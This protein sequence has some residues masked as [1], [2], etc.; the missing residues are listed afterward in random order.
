MSAVKPMVGKT[1]SRLTVVA[2]T[3][4]STDGKAFWLCR[5]V[6]G[7]ETCVE[8]KKLRAGHTRSCGCFAR[9]EQ[10]RRGRE[11]IRHGHARTHSAKPTPEYKTWSS[12]IGRCTNPIDANYAR[13]G[14]RGI[15]VCRRW[16]RF[17]NFLA[18]MGM[19]PH[20][21]LSIDRR[22]NNKGYWKSN[23]RWAT[24]KEQQRNK[25]SNH[26]LTVDGE[27]APLVVW[28]DRYGLKKQTLRMRLTK[29]WSADRAVKEPLHT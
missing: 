18:D 20:A 12:I 15:T 14:G 5:C 3:T 4:T 6:C 24:R 22:D 13:Y 7:R 11:A 29:G 9:E 2:R 16:R 17:E 21:G 25:R 28:A 19:R 26:L 10:V 8:G 27:T 23:C 1:F